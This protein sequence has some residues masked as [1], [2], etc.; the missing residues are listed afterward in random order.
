MSSLS[1]LRD[2]ILLSVLV[3][4]LMLLCHHSELHRPT[5][6]SSVN[7]AHHTSSPLPRPRRLALCQSIHARYVAYCCADQTATND[8][9]DTPRSRHKNPLAHQAVA[10]Q[11]PE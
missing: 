10:H 6:S 3:H 9:L 4:L 11:Y 8:P 5:Q 2:G 7:V 1:S